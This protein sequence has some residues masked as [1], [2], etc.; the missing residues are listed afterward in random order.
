MK[1]LLLLAVLGLFVGAQGL[2]KN[3]YSFTVQF[4]D[5]IV[6]TV[7]GPDISIGCNKSSSCNGNVYFVFDKTDVCGANQPCSSQDTNGEIKVTVDVP[8]DGTQVF[9][10]KL[11]DFPPIRLNFLEGKLESV[12]YQKIRYHKDIHG[13][14]VVAKITFKQSDDDFHGHGY[15]NANI[16][17]FSTVVYFKYQFQDPPT[18]P[19]AA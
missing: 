19:C 18:V 2:P 17:D 12:P 7:P 13:Q 15:L 10:L 9:K 4:S 3:W 16:L 8:G 5:V 14:T 11:S 6:E 1:I